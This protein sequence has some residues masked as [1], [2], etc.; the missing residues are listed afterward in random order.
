MAEGKWVTV[1]GNKMPDG[2]PARRWKTADGDLQKV[3]SNFDNWGWQDLLNLND[4]NSWGGPGAAK[5]STP[6]ADDTIQPRVY[7]GKTK[8]RTP[9][10]EDAGDKKYQDIA[11]NGWVPPIDTTQ[12]ANAPIVMRSHNEE[13]VQKKAQWG[14]NPEVKAAADKGFEMGQAY[15]EGDPYGTVPEYINAGSS[16]YMERADMK[17]WAEANP[18][19]AAALR[20]K[21]TRREARWAERERTQN[22]AFNRTDDGASASSGAEAIGRASLDDGQATAARL[23]AGSIGAAVSGEG[24]SAPG[25]SSEKGARAIGSM[26][27]KQPTT[28]NDSNNFEIGRAAALDKARN[29]DNGLK[30]VQEAAITDSMDQNPGMT[31]GQ[32]MKNLEAGRTPNLAQGSPLARSVPADRQV[33]DEALDAHMEVR[34]QA[35]NQASTLR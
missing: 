22:A 9:G 29:F 24:A 23:G 17:V 4:A 19:A 11:K 33:S 3:Q 16:E 27:G 26:T 31:R 5:A 20:A 25:Q 14:D 10:W 1:P 6:K 8:L 21:G 28:L 18:E 7:D 13:Y 34:G 32:A 15:R 12:N 35:R 30:E 2:K